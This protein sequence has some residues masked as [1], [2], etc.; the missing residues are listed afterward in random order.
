MADDAQTRVTL[1]YDGAVQF[2]PRMPTTKPKTI[3]NKLNSMHVMATF[4][5]ESR[6]LGAPSMAP[7]HRADD[8]VVCLLHIF[9]K[10]S[11]DDGA[12]NRLILPR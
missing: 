11:I 1:A 4:M 10:K 9:A 8:D 3:S 6:S 2:A 5:A 7:V 12:R